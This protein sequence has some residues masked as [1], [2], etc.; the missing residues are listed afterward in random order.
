MGKFVD[1]TGLQYGR[2]TVINRADVP[3]PKDKQAVWECLCECGNTILAKG[4]YL[5]SGQTK[6]CGCLRSDSSRERQ[7]KHGGKKT[8]TYEIW[9]GMN[10]RCSNVKN[11]QY[12]DYGGRGINVCDGWREDYTQFLADMG[13]RPEGLSIERI[14]NDLGY[15]KDNC[16]WATH[17][18][19][20]NNTRRSRRVVYGGVEMTVPQLARK[21]GVNYDLLLERI[22]RQGWPVEEAVNLPSQAN[23]YARRTK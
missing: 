5:Q 3:Q 14:N 12:A 7:Y 22:T 8:P 16:K 23:G 17:T 2:L 6:S 18:E 19:Q 11:K 4:G 13:A 20:M 9:K 10:S 21:T 1:K 15:S